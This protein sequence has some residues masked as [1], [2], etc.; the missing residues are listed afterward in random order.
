MRQMRDELTH[1]RG[2]YDAPP[3]ALEV[4]LRRRDSRQRAKRLGTAAFALTIGLAAVG[5]VFASSADEVPERGLESVGTDPSG[6]DAGKI[7]F[8]RWSSGEWHLYSMSEDGSGEQQLTK[9]S[10][11]FYAEISPDGTRIVAD[12]ELPGTDGLLVMSIDGTDRRTFPV[13]D[14]MDPSWSP[15]GNRI[16]F[17]L[18]SGAAD[19]CLTLWVMNADGSGLARLGNARGYSPTWSP[20]GTKIA[21]LMSGD[22]LEAATLLAVMASDGSDVT[23]ITEPG[24]WGEPDWSPDGASILTSL[25]RGLIHADLLTVAPD[26]TDLRVIERL[27]TL[28]RAHW[29]PDGTQI[30]Y[31]SK[32]QVWVMRAD[33]SGAHRIT[34]SAEIENPTWG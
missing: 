8:S 28:G 23:P 30:T 17:T 4:F 25:D 10:R 31:V 20:D 29:S 26:G 5:V 21:F 32:G 22:G 13:G 7:L 33:G 12:T 9:G 16:A 34:A 2:R 3:E 24:W 6:G 1:A 14:A 27:P 18:D 11:D 15:D 19:C